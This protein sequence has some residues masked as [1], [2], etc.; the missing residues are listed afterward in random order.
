MPPGHG[1]LSYAARSESLNRS[2]HE[3]NS[4]TLG[5]MSFRQEELGKFQDMP[6]DVEIF[7]SAH[8]VPLSY[9][10][11]AGDP[12][13]VGRQLF[14]SVSTL[15]SHHFPSNHWEDA[16]E[17]RE[18]GAGGLGVIP[19][20]SFAICA[21]AICAYAICALSKC[22]CRS[23]AALAWRPRWLCET[24]GP[25]ITQLWGVSGDDRLCNKVKSKHAA[26][27]QEEMEECV[28]A[29]LAELRAR[30]IRN[31]WTLA[32]QSRVGPVEWLKPYT[33]ESIRRVICLPVGVAQALHRRVHQASRVA[34]CTQAA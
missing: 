33:D 10:E 14:S 2:L 7:F 5:R 11:E 28:A 8:G 25:A 26:Q 24:S 18:K 9:V 16:F 27:P 34:L 12:Y 21:H 13:K 1:R 29:I 6:E 4:T 19:M 23:Y 32:Y 20:G 17:T 30:G 22:S 31:T 3:A 15:N